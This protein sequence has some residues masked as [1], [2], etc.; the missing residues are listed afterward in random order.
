[1]NES[2]PK[3]LVCQVS[4]LEMPLLI[5]TYRGQQIFLCPQ[6]LPLLIHHPEKLVG[7]LPGA[8]N[9]PAREHD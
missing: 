5:L 7:I 8:E 4:S 6:H 2:Q 1:M 3:C 9:W